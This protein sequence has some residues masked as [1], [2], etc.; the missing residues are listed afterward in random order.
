MHEALLMSSLSFWPTIIYKQ[1]IL[2]IILDLNL[3]RYLVH[4][5]LNLRLLQSI[6]VNL[7]D[8]LFCL[9]KKLLVS[10]IFSRRLWIWN[11]LDG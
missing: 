11:L 3:S 9:F 6:A 1:I 5:L 10:F 8:N 7:P 4:R 2:I